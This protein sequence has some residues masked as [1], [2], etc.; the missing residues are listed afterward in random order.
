MLKSLFEPKEKKTLSKGKVAA[1]ILLIVVLGAIGYAL[2]TF[3]ARAKK[4]MSNVLGSTQQIVVKTVAPTVEP[5]SLNA[6]FMDS[7]NEIASGASALGTQALQSAVGVVK[8]EA[9]KIIIQQ[10]ASTV[11]TEI[12]KLPQDQQEQIKNALCK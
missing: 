4:D 5:V 12:E 2:F 11:M 8:E 7:V 3:N 6:F 10:T 9:T 1:R